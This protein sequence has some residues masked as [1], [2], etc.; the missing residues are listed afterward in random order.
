MQT[1]V[2]GRITELAHY[3]ILLAIRSGDIAIDATAG[4]GYDTLFLAERVGPNGHVYAFDVQDEAL[5]KTAM[6]LKY[7]NLDQRVTLVKDSHCNLSNYFREKAS[8]IMYNL[9]YLPGGDLKVTTDSTSTLSS[10]KQALKLLSPGGIITVVLYPG[11]P[12]GSLEKEELILFCRNLGAPDF[13]V[14][15]IELLN[16]NNKPPELIVIQKTM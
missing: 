3:F 7:N 5:A 13:S 16:R 4:N 1:E 10:L 2:I 14:I 9:G 8:V 11:H 12:E 6:R 15:Q